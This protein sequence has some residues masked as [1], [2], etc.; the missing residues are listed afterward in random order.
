[1]HYRRH[2]LYSTYSIAPAVGYRSSA[3]DS[4]KYDEMRLARRHLHVFPTTPR[5]CTH[6]FPV[7]L[8]AAVCTTVHPAIVP[9]AFLISN[10]ELK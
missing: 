9:H 2:V 4:K 3:M 1:M 7:H 8:A 5:R 10:K 6:A